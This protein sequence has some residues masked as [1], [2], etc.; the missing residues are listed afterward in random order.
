MTISP[1]TSLHLNQS[2]FQDFLDCPRRFELHFLNETSWPAA[3]GSP[4]LKFERLTETGNRFHQLCQQF[5][6]GIDGELLSRSIT[7]PQ[8]GDLWDSFLPYGRS[9]QS[10]PGL[11]EQ[12]LRIPFG[13][14]FLDAKFDLIV[15]LPN[16][17]FLIIDWKTAAAKPSRTILAN[18][19]QTYLYPYILKH[20]G[21]DLFPNSFSNTSSIAM[22]YYYP[23]SS[24][25]E[26]FFAYSEEEETQTQ[27]KITSLIDQIQEKMNRPDPFPMTEDQ[28]KCQYC[29]YRSYCERGFDTSPL[30]P[31]LEIENE[32]LTNVHFNIDLIQEIDY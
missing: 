6:I 17:S 7:D 3:Q 4:L 24:S 22:Q 26:E 31:G 19:V 18:R 28:K 20:A 15:Q 11:S 21:E 32:D 29:L 5:F 12:I 13:D 14:H 1:M 25:P 23:L 10:H 8:L 2:A 16:D 27:H 30:P 9:I